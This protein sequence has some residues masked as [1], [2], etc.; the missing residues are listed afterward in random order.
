MMYAI[1]TIKQNTSYD[2][3]VIGGGASGMMAAGR[4]A[5]RGKRV[6]LLEK[7][8][9]LGVKLKI[10]GGG[11]C[12]VTNAEE[13][14]RVLL[15]KYGV[16]EK[17]LY[18]P[19]S[20][21][22]V[23]ETFAFFSSRGLPLVV[24]AHK[25][26]FPKTQKA[27]DVFLVLENNLKQFGVAVKTQSAVT[28]IVQ[29]DNRIVAVMIGK[30]AY[31]ANTF[32]L[33]TGGVSHPE[34]GSTGDGFVWLKSLGLSVQDPTPSLVPIAI[35]DAWVKKRSGISLDQ[36]RITF[37]MD[38]MR[39][40]VVKGRVLFT[41]FGLSGPAI[42]N[43]SAKI[44]DLLHEG[45]VTGLLDLFPNTDHGMLD[46]ELV[47]FLNANKNKSFK[48]CFKAFV[49]DGMSEAVLS[50]ASFIDPE[51]KVHSLKKDQR[52]QLI[53]RMKSMPFTVDGLMGTDM[54]IVSD[55]GLPLS[56][57]DAK[58]MHVKKYDNLYVTGDLLNIRRPSGGF[59]LQLCWTTG[60]VAGEN[61]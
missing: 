3:I 44:A 61:C 25:R 51:T 36:T 53:Q 26:A 21:F 28:N 50:L 52:K 6:L 54:A 46:E 22:G 55:G 39:A 31:R 2:V 43:A 23:K 59:S 11:R 27:M 4:A 29:E 35:T 48:T 49:P 41:H 45:E 18:S 57:I 34:T 9:E 14:I 1:M 56:E 40:L 60:F 15:P 32:I 5:E 24:E 20:R 13:D 47:H 37:F 7:N 30:I 33:A 17:F 42:L 10:S 58:T 38:G 12:N 8:K 19:F 16:A